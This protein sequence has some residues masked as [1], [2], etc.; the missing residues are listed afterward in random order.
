MKR[1]NG[2]SLKAALIASALVV[3]LP[4]R[5]GARDGN[6]RPQEARYSAREN[7]QET[8]CGALLGNRSPRIAGAS[9]SELVVGAEPGNPKVTVSLKN[10]KCLRHG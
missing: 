9:S 2:I 3:Y 5:P 7:N 4:C 10:K 6:H 8:D 1:I